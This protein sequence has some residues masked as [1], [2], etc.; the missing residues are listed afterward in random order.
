VT[1]AAAANPELVYALL[2][3]RDLFEPRE[4][5]AEHDARGFGDGGAAEQ[6]FREANVSGDGATPRAT[7]APR[8]SRANLRGNLRRMLAH[9]DEKI[10]VTNAYVTAERVMEIAA[11]AA[12]SFEPEHAEGAVRFEPTPFA[13]A[14]SPETARTFFAPLAWRLVVEQEGF[15]WD[16]KTLLG[17][18]LGRAVGEA[19]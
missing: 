5:D 9:L 10:E 3:R 19:L 6:A 2:H 8:S 15:E 18:M 11:R 17:G 13:Y 7:S 16:E 4:A 14:S 1:H 12:A